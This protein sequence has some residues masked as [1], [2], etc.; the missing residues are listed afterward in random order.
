ME[1]DAQKDSMLSDADGTGRCSH[2]IGG[3]LRI[4][5]LIP[6]SQAGYAS[7]VYTT[8]RHRVIGG[9]VCESALHEGEVLSRLGHG[10]HSLH[11]LHVWILLFSAGE[12][13]VVKRAVSLWA[14][15]LELLNELEMGVVKQSPS[16]E[17]EEWK[18]C[19]GG[20]WA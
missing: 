2:G 8:L 18:R 12:E 17:K 9:R 15:K 1:L 10:E 19:E 20:C 16:I 3:S 4:L 14:M 13:Y 11:R 5:H 6:P 7:R